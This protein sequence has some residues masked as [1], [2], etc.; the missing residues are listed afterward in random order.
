M[1]RI[2]RAHP[3]AAYRFAANASNQTY[4]ITDGDTGSA[5]EQ[6]GVEVLPA[7]DIGSVV[8]AVADVSQSQADTGG[9][10]DAHSLEVL[11]GGEA[12][13]ATDAGTAPS[14]SLSG[15]EVSTVSDAAVSIDRDAADVGS[16]V[17]AVVALDG[18]LDDI[19]TS[20]QGAVESGTVE[21]QLSDGDT[22]VGAETQDI[23]NDISSGDSVNSSEA[24]GALGVL[25][26]GGDAGTALE[27]LGYREFGAA[28]VGVGAESATPGPQQSDTG[29]GADTAVDFGV[30]GEGDAGTVADAASALEVT[31]SGDTAVGADA[32]SLPPA[33]V[34]SSDTVSAVEAVTDISF[35]DPPGSLR[36]DLGLGLDSVVQVDISGDDATSGDTA[37]TVEVSPHVSE[38][39]SVIDAVASLNILD[40]DG[41]TADDASGGTPLSNLVTSSDI[42]HFVDVFTGISASGLSSGDI[43]SLL[44]EPHLDRG[45]PTERQVI[46]GVELRV[47]YVGETARVTTLFEEVRLKAVPAESRVVEVPAD[48]RALSSVT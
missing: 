34:D 38:A 23:G 7:G 3:V 32:G 48:A 19:D 9:S 14:S 41:A 15:A 8:D 1:A 40:S 25:P 4:Q 24:A 42:A 26:Q 44:D 18:E 12:A 33:S 13:S 2:G 17:D 10:A 37:E 31:P 43:V 29:T 16:T 36:S 30:S 35:P 27:A 45:T 22:G 28:D 46:V 39:G 47:R 11:P 5:S 6:V 20:I 21:F